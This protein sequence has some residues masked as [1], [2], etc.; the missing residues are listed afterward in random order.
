M[1]EAPVRRVLLSVAKNVFRRFHPASK[2]A[3]LHLFFLLRNEP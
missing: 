1:A 3:V 2:T